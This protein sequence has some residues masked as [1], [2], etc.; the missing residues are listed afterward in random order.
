MSAAVQLDIKAQRA[1]AQMPARERIRLPPSDEHEMPW[2][3]LD[4]RWD[5]MTRPGIALSRAWLPFACRQ[6]A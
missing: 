6:A 1:L 5:V 4:W 3:D 2:Y